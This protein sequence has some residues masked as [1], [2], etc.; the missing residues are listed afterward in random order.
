MGNKLLLVL[1]AALIAASAYF[2]LRT[3]TREAAATD[4]AV[5]LANGTEKPTG[6]QRSAPDA[7][8]ASELEDKRPT[9]EAESPT[10]AREEVALEVLPAWATED[11]IE[12]EGLVLLPAGTPAD[13]RLRVTISKIAAAEDQESLEYSVD[14]DA[15]GHFKF[16]A[17]P[18]PAAL[19][20]E[21]E[22]RYLFTTASTTVDPETPP[23][24]EPMLGAWV[25]GQLEL[26]KGLGE[27]D[28]SV[29][30]ISATAALDAG[31]D[32]RLERRLSGLLG[33]VSPDAAGAFEIF[34]IPCGDAFALSADA[35]EFPKAITPGLD[36]R[37]GQHM[38]L[39]LQLDP[40]SSITGIAVDDSGEPIPNV[41][42][43]ATSGGQFDLRA[44]IDKRGTHSAEDGTFRIAGLPP[45]ELRLVASVEGFLLE[46]ELKLELAPGAERTDV[47][48]RL[49]RG[50]TVRGHVVDTNGAPVAWANVDLR[51]D[52]AALTGV[53]AA[54][55]RLG[56]TGS[57][58]ADEAGHFEIHGLGLGPFLLTAE[59]TDEAKLWHFGKRAGV[60]PDG[61]EIELVVRALSPLHGRVVD[62]SGKPIES[63]E[64]EVQAGNLGGLMSGERYSETFQDP[65]GRF[66]FAR[67]PEGDWNLYASAEGFGR[68][69]PISVD[70]P[71]PG[72]TEIVVEMSRGV[73]AKGKVV[74]PSGAAVAGATVTWQA[75]TGDLILN[76]VGL[77]PKI[78]AT[79]SK[80]GLFE[81]H[82]L[83]SGS[84][85]LT[86]TAAAWAAPEP[87]TLDAM[88]DEVVEGLMFTMLT[89]GSISGEVLDDEGD[90]ETGALVQIQ[91][92][93][94]S[95]Q[96]ITHTDENGE[97]L[98][99]KLEPGK[100]QVIAISSDVQDVTD[101]AEML[102]NL[103]MDMVD[104]VDGETVHVILGSPP[105][106]P[107]HLSGRIEPADSVSGGIAI[108]IPEGDNLL[109]AMRMTSIDEEGH[110]E[111][112]LDG[113]GKYVI[114]IQTTPQGGVGQDSVEFQ[115]E[116]P[117][118]REITRVFRLPGGS[119]SGRVRDAH[120]RPIAAIRVSLY[121]DGGT[122]T[123]TLSGGK[124]TETTTD[125]DGSY[126]IGHLSAGS[127]T[128][129]AG[130]RSLNAI[131][132]SGGEFGRKVLG[133]LIVGEDKELGGVDFE[134]EGAGTIEGRVVGSD[135]KPV[136]S[137]SLFVRDEAGNLLERISLATTGNDGS[138][139]YSGVAAGHYTIS[140]RSKT[141]TSPAP[142][143]V[144][145]RSGES[146]TAEL[147]LTTGT[148]L[149][150][151]VVNKEGDPLSASLQ[152][153]DENGHDVAGQFGMSDLAE[154]LSGEFSTTTQR[155]GPLPPGKYKV[156]GTSGDLFG[157]KPVNLTG[158]ERRRIRLRLK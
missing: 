6:T 56:A 50:A 8:A 14:V 138:F 85:T 70:R 134:L 80:D 33:A 65:E 75:D 153:L 97:F 102:K 141:E 29:A 96:T 53:N 28:L 47:E 114:T 61:D 62:A 51:F 120:G 149:E 142:V 24:I 121:A 98:V 139:S 99:E 82:D 74:D 91:T 135:G 105:E 79:T 2:L 124:Y 21:L 31:F 12:R 19:V 32:T 38:E 148:I 39:T 146:A 145:V 34:G 54:N 43:E 77:A 78:T 122:S 92:T 5:E 73:I 64:I 109:G 127:Y 152:V 26:P 81:L 71:G 147:R 72:E 158:Q 76:L 117:A 83:P 66:E 115:E 113:P 107:V 137:A 22:G 36:L 20:I 136:A 63:F 108:L 41:A 86:A 57:A 118:Q 67:V 68:I 88:P 154:L 101:Q 10:S 58:Q 49:S 130:G 9:A 52:P 17:P 143:T 1:A 40:G 94:G 25:S 23:V 131:M 44:Q 60:K 45:G 15:Q 55:S 37:P 140:A 116:L 150:I 151:S 100:W 128:V 3:P 27:F 126:S 11:A 95:K 35:Q 144:V 132:N 89:G 133:G 46:D 156:T 123:G 103:K 18:G 87:Q 16:S 157:K 155:F 30:E 90:P 111:I 59:F 129:G 112:D 104:V 119:I 4:A 106:D 125:A 48:I 84:L 42:I 7:L 93:G 69:G 13:E 110:F